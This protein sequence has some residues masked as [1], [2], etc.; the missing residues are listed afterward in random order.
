M[1]RRERRRLLISLGI[2]GVM[3]VLLCVGVWFGAFSNLHASGRDRLFQTWPA[4]GPRDV[5]KNVVIVAIDDASI[6]R[7]GRFGEWPRRYYAQVVDKVREAHGR[8][9]VFDVGFFEPQADDPQVIAALNRFRQLSIEEL[10]AAGVSPTPRGVISPAIGPQEAA[11]VEPGRMPYMSGIQTPTED[12]VRATTIL[13]HANTLPDPDGTLR[14]TPLFMQLGERH[15]PSL[16]LAA[17]AAYSGRLGDQAE[18]LARPN[19]QLPLVPFEQTRGSG[20]SVDPG[21][22]YVSAVGRPIPVNDRYQMII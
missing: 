2:S 11:R 15:V 21:T 7:L 9:I 22:G 3:A 16:S 14:T 5:A 4:A 10:R 17:A 1:T 18:A 13:A 6:Q 20:F 19:Y 8:L 12:Y